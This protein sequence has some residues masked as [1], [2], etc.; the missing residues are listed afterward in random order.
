M[1]A[2]VALVAYLIAVLSL[3]YRLGG[4]R[5][6]DLERRR[7]TVLVASGAVFTLLLGALFAV[8]APGVQFY[9]LV[10]AAGAYVWLRRLQDSG[11]WLVTPTPAERA[12]LPAR[13]EAMSAMLRR[14]SFWILAGALTVGLMVI[15][16]G[17]ALLFRG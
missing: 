15:T 7:M 11:H 3:I 13:R 16:V 9:G 14:P 2:G 4:I 12:A 8:R 5:P 17:A 1:I 10:V 6:G